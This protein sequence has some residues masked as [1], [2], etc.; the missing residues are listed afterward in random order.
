MPRRIK[1]SPIFIHVMTQPSPVSRPSARSRKPKTRV[2]HATALS[3]SPYASTGTTCGDFQRSVTWKKYALQVRASRNDARDARR[4]L[5]SAGLNCEPGGPPADCPDPVKRYN[6]LR[7]GV[8]FPGVKFWLSLVPPRMP[9]ETQD[10]PPMMIAAGC[11][12]K[13]PVKC[14]FADRHITVG[15]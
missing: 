5:T 1:P 4:D 14:G 11:I 6:P 3:T 9:K 7:N 8:A 15:A 13:D 2:S 12:A 10:Y